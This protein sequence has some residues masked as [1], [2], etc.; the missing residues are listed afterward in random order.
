L[1]HRNRLAPAPAALVLGLALAAAGAFAPALAPAPA[2]ATTFTTPAL[3]DTIQHAAFNY[4]WNEANPANGLVKDRSAAWSPC[5]IA[6][7][8]FGLSAITAGWRARRGASGA[9]PR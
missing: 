6:A 2:G 7:T 4:F 3:L 9:W 5:S 8:G 1:R